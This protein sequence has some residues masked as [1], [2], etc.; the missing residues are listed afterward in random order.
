MLISSRRQMKSKNFGGLDPDQNVGV[1]LLT[2]SHPDGSRI[3]F[4]IGYSFHTASIREK[5]NG[6]F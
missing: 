4:H 2:C 5:T 6:I 3:Y 1:T